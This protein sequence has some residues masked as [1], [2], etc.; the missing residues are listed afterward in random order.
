MCGRY[1]MALRPSELRQWLQDDDMPVDDSPADDGDGAPRQ[2]Y[3]FAPGYHG[4]VYRADTPSHGGGGYSRQAGAN[5]GSNAGSNAGP[6]DRAEHDVDAAETDDTGA[7]KTSDTPTHYKLQTMK[8]GL[9]PSWTKKH[10]NPSN[11]SSSYSS[12]LK[13]IN[14]RADSLAMPGGMWAS[15]KT[16]KRCVIIAQGFYEWLSRP[17]GGPKDKVPHFVK[18]RDGGLMFF[19]GLWD[20][21]RGEKG[22]GEKGEGEKGGEGLYT[23][24]VITTDSNKQLKFLHD[25]MPVILE[26]GSEGLWRWLDPKRTEWNGELQGLLK[27]FEGEVEVYP[28]S[29]E[30][31][32]VGNNSPSFVIPVASRENKG[33]I[34][35]FFAAAA[36]KQKGVEVKMETGASQGDEETKTETET[37]GELGK[38]GR[39]DGT[40]SPKKGI[41][42]EADSS[43]TKEQPPSKK[44]ASFKSAS[45]MKQKPQARGKISATSNAQRSPV[46]ARGKPD[47]SQKITKFFGNTA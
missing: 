14:C 5:A 27:P 23:Y 18:R 11:P 3:N 39:N 30:V 9:I 13:T 37:V 35:N 31:G 7:P 40:D 47:G 34:A 38:M 26:A 4:V 17:G 28:V 1:A 20:C 46:K 29:K 42:R 24:T 41:K 15:M 10:N 12:L 32:K 21:V 25:R 45:P 33:N 36:G 22:E 6:N 43:P 44:T 2:S 16:R 19:A 8:W